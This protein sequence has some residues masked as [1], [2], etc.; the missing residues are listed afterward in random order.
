VR[1]SKIRK[2]SKIC[3]IPIQVISAPQNFSGRS[4]AYIK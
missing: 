4:S 2:K 1:A 3:A